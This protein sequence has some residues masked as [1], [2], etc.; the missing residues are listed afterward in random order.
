M[1]DII[2]ELKALDDRYPWCNDF[3]EMEIIVM[4]A[5]GVDENDSVHA[6]SINGPYVLTGA[7]FITLP[8]G[9]GFGSAQPS[10]S[11]SREEGLVNANGLWQSDVSIR[12]TIRSSVYY[13]FNC[14]GYDSCPINARH[15]VPMNSTAE[16]PLPVHSEHRRIPGTAQAHLHSGVV[17]PT[18]KLPM[19]K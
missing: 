7:P 19:R 1:V 5:E 11:K 2:N 6:D 17:Y 8:L 14:R 13:Q 12:T 18:N 9:L 3:V 15:P 16:A 10:K 4:S